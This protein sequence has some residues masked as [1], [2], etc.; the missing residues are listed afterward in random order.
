MKKKII[1]TGSAG[2]VGLNLL[3]QLDPNKH[4]VIAIDQNIHNIKLSKRIFPKFKLTNQR[5]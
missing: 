1:I 2:L 4:E 5:V 3:T